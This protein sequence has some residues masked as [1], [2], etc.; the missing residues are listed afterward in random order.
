MRTW[1]CMTEPAAPKS[2]VKAV[3][4]ATFD[5]KM[6]PVARNYLA[7]TFSREIM[8]E[9]A[10]KSMSFTSMSE[11]TPKSLAIIPYPTLN[12]KGMIKNIIYSNVGRR[13]GK[14]D[15]CLLLVFDEQ[16]DL[17][18]Y[19]YIKEFEKVFDTFVSKFIAVEQGPADVAT[20]ESQK[21]LVAFYDETIRLVDELSKAELK[22]T[23]QAFPNGTR[24]DEHKIRYKIVV[25]GD[26]E[27]GKTS[28]VLNFTEK[29][30]S[31]VY[32][33]TIGVNISEKTI[34]AP[35]KRVEFVIWDIAGHAKFLKMR[36][37]FYEGAETALLVFDLTRPDTFKSVSAW[38]ADV[39]R[40]HDKTFMP[41]MVGNKS[42]LLA[43]RKVDKQTASDAAKLLGI[44]YVETS[45]KTGEN[46]QETFQKLAEHLLNLHGIK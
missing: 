40:G 46:I 30:F 32:I 5:E 42:D 2:L 31:R 3:I 35:N 16:N 17:I 9:I 38:Y 43:E 37:H 19:R 7:T 14:G 44:P 41:M 4:F 13:G 36:R 20:K 24:D 45:A 39:S 34:V 12:S 33:P 10:F 8:D 28:M 29:A 6:G 23:N 11:G 27:V 26:P 18:F 25:I 15:C 1:E 22:F 21:V